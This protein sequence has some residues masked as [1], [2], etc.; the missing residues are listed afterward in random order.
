MKDEH[1]LNSI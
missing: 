1:Q